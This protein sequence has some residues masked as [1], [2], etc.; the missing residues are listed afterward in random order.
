MP[1][2]TERRV[3]RSRAKWLLFSMALITSMPACGS[4]PFQLF[5]D[6]DLTSESW[7]INVDVSPVLVDNTIQMRVGERLSMSVVA[8]SSGEGCTVTT[9]PAS[10]YGW[11]LGSP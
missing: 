11:R 1:E 6:C 9:S 4:G 3:R 8:Y 2:Q 5:P 10:T 7:A